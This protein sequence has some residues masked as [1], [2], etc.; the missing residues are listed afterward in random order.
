M[1]LGQIVAISFA[2]NLSFLAFTVFER[3]NSPDTASKNEASKKSPTAGSLFLRCSWLILLAATI[4]CAITIPDKLDHPKFMYLLLVPHI[5]AFIPLLLNRLVS[6]GN[7]RD[8][9]QQPRLYVHI[10]FMACIVAISTARVRTMEENGMI[11]E[12]PCMSTR[13]SAVLGGISSAVGLV[14]MRGIY[15]IDA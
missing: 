2:A 11:L 14:S 8:L 3:Q 7:H 12:E 6:I 13:L 1:L 10:F 9:A 4:R 15:L 5:S